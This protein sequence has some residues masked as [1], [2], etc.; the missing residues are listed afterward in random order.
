MKEW[1]TWFCNS[2]RHV[3]ETDVKGYRVSTVFLGLDHS[4]GDGDPVLFETMVFDPAGESVSM[5][6]YCTWAEAEAGHTMAV[7]ALGVIA[8]VA[9]G[10][11]GALLNRLRA[12][13][14]L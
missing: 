10:E 13:R 9:T 14:P 12:L 11:T 3:G 4:H 7:A 8:A 2:E 5:D 6:R 1:A